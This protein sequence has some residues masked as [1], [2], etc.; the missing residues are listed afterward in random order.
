[1]AEKPD[2]ELV[3]IIIAEDPLLL[4]VPTTIALMEPY[5]AEIR[6]PASATPILL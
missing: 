1:M 2:Q 5:T 3:I 4:E 6:R